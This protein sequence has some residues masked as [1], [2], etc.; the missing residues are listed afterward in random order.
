MKFHQRSGLVLFLVGLCLA[1][2][3]YFQ[4]TITGETLSVITGIFILI[5]LGLGV[6][7]FLVGEE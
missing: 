5:F 7:L 1:H 2:A 6:L 4:F 3:D